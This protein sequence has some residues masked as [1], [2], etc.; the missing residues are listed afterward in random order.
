MANLVYDRPESLA[1][2]LP[3]GLPA[4]RIEQVYHPRADGHAANECLGTHGF[5]LG[6]VGTRDSGLGSQETGVGRKSP[7]FPTPDSR[8][9]TVILRK[10]TIY[11]Q[12]SV[13]V[14]TV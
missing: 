7:E 6:R 9:P 11:G 4:L 2:P 3:A 5:P 8:L 12:S 10:L 1:Q 14:L 13:T